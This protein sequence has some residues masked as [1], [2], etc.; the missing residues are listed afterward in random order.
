MPTS[1]APLAF[2]ALADALRA[3]ALPAE[4]QW[5]AQ[6]FVLAPHEREGL[7]AL[8][9]ECH[10]RIADTIGAQLQE[11]ART[12]YPSPAQLA[13]R[14]AFIAKA[15]HDAGGEASYGTWAYFAWSR[16]V[17]HLLPED[18]YYAVITS[19]N[20][21][22]ITLGEQATLRTKRVAVIG[23]SVGGE[24]AVGIAQEHL[25]GE[26]VI[27]DFDELDLSNLNRLQAGIDELGENKA[28]IV[29][30]RIA[31]LNPYL[32]LRVFAD[33]VTA[34]NIGDFLDGVDLLVEE[35]DGLTIKYQIREKAKRRGINIIFG[36]DERGFLSIEPHAHDPSFPIFHGRIT[37]PP[38]PRAEYP[39][40]L[41]FFK[42]LAEWIGGWEHIS[43]RSRDS[44]LAV[45]Q[46]L[47][48][49]PQLAS[50]ARFNAGVL[51]HTARVMLL[52]AQLPAS[53]QYIDLDELVGMTPRTA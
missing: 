27:A 18:D 19:R 6:F 52:G 7:N 39:D 24:A 22:K 30:R 25:C 32:P 47:C 36:A 20:H 4:S 10:L 3:N 44:L 42:A 16:T 33:G 43:Q 23:L 34:S 11:L 21:D 49:Y 53:L 14:D 26:L 8:A 9:V 2:S 45:E 41:S 40:A 35:C 28:H 50:E 48:G 13:E 29:A 15:L 12:R 31:R 37:A 46:R 17:V 38:K 1:A 5:R 51:G